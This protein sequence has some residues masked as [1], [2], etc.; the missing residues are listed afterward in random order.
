MKYKL[1][2]SDYDG[3]L[4]VAPKNDIDIENLLCVRTL[5]MLFYLI[6]VTHVGGDINSSLKI[7]QL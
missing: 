2:I 4:G 7:L 1:F 5:T 3:T 6:F